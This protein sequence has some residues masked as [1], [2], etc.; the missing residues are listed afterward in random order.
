MIFLIFG[1]LLA[2]FSSYITQTFADAYQFMNA[3]RNIFNVISSN[4]LSYYGTLLNELTLKSLIDFYY[5]L[6]SNL[7]NIAVFNYLYTYFLLV[8]NPSFLTTIFNLPPNAAIPDV[9]L[10]FSLTFYCSLNLIQTI[11]KIFPKISKPFVLQILFIINS[12]CFGVII[13]GII[14]LNIVII[15]IPA[16]IIIL[17]FAY[18]ALWLPI[19]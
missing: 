6:A 10:G 9:I 4:M 5:E 18:V 13:V 8:G 7:Y 15:A 16:L 12:I 14:F 11:F 17:T 19:K 2:V 3:L 1:T